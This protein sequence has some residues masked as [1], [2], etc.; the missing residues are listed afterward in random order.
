[1]SRLV[2]VTL[3]ALSAGC[4]QNAFFELQVQLP[5]DPDPSDEIEW[6]AQI[7]VRDQTGHGL[8]VNWMG[9]D[10]PTVPL[11]DAARW[12]CLSVQSQD[13]GISLN[14]RVRFCRDPRCLAFED[15]SAPER[16]Y[17][18]ETPFYVGARTYYQ[19]QIPQIPACVG[20]PTDCAMTP[21][22]CGGGSRCTCTVDTDCEGFGA[23]YRCEPGVGCVLEVGRCQIEGCIEG[24]ISNFCSTT[25]GEHFCEKNPEITRNDT[26]MCTLP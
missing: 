6:F 19:V 1:M 15:S 24:G 20:A 10:L 11:S 9:G 14:V 25:T 26:F 7:Q 13:P 18:F 3:V 8:D 17:S 4:T 22:D 16:L 5:A 23:G 12:E 2:L 21:G